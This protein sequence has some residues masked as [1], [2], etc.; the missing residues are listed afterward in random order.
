LLKKLLF[1]I[2]CF[3]HLC[4]KSVGH[5]GFI[6]GDFYSVVLVFMSVFVLVLCCFYCYG[7]VLFLKSGIVIP[8]VLLFLFSIAL[9]IHSLLCFQMRFRVDFS[10]SEM[11]VIGILM[12]IALNM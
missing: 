5:I 7:S 12:E 4:Q 2:I 9:A 3:W 8:P 10:I 1:S 11:N 6:S